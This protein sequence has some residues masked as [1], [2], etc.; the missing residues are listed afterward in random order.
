MD[1]QPK[2][3]ARARSPELAGRVHLIGER[4][5]VGDV[6]AALDVFV[7]TSDQEGLSNAML[8]AMAAGVPVVSTPVSGAHEALEPG[9]TTGLPGIVVKS[10]DQAEIQAAVASVL[11]D[12]AARAGMVQAARAIARER[13]DLEHMLDDWEVVL[14]GNAPDLNKNLRTRRQ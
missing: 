13:F 4:S 3:E 11:A 1:E 6:L 5:D 12:A 7:I 2:L 10:F 8:E 9:V 14:R